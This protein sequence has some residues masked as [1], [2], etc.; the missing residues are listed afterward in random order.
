[1]RRLGYVL[2]SLVMAM[3]LTG[4][5]AL[6]DIEWCAEDPIIDVLGTRF[7]LT[8]QIGTSAASVSKISYVVELPS[9][10]GPVRVSFPPGDALAAITDVQIVKTGEPVEPGDDEFEVRATVTVTAPGGT[11]VILTSGGRS[12]ERL[13]ADGKA[14][15]PVTLKFEVRRGA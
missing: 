5:T 3:S 15:R 11:P 8:T 1:M 6:A 14:N 2:A 9:N 10:A 12:A 7:D 4:T 13:E